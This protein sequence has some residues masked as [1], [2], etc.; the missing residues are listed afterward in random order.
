MI[1]SMKDL[2]EVKAENKEGDIEKL[3]LVYEDYG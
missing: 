3:G 1:D 2:Y